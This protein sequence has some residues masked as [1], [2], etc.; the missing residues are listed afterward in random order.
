MGKEKPK[1]DFLLLGLRVSLWGLIVSFGVMI[2]SLLFF[3]YKGGFIESFLIFVI[4]FI[5]ILSTLVFSIIFLLKHKDKK[6][7]FAVLTL[8]LSLITL[9]I[10]L[11]YY[12]FPK[13][14]L[15]RILHCR[16]E[17]GLYD[18]VLC[19]RGFPGSVGPSCINT[20]LRAT[21]VTCSGTPTNCTVRLERRGV[22]TAEIGGVKLVFKNTTAGT[23]SPLVDV[24]GNIEPSASIEK[25]IS[26]GLTSPN[27]V[28][29]TAY[30]KDESGI[31]RICGQ[32]SPFTF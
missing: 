11:S 21:A 30:F 8:V 14:D 9:I 3:I 2:F 25:T 19:G 23:S 17:A 22:E 16:G 5:S 7:F 6:K 26:T 27:K 29:V 13:I 24:S 31:E 28:E 10:L 32:T 12:F 20:E 15:I 4:F 18:E 1:K